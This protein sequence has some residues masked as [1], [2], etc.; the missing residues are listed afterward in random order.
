VRGIVTAIENNR[1]SEFDVTALARLRVMGG[2]SLY[3]YNRRRTRLDESS[4]EEQVLLP[5]L[6]PSKAGLVL[7][8]KPSSLP[9]GLAT[10]IIGVIAGGDWDAQP[11][12]LK[13]IE[14]PRDLEGTNLVA[15]LGPPG[16]SLYDLIDAR[17][18]TVVQGLGDAGALLVRFRD[19]W[20]TLGGASAQMPF[21]LDQVVAG[22]RPLL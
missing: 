9:T 1:G 21:K 15:A 8:V 18:L 4:T 22:L 5:L 3:Y 10:R 14:L 19:E 11:D 6:R 20:C 13:K 12:D 16:S 2:K 17:A 7:V